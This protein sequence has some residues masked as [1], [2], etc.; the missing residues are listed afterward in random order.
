MSI[1]GKAY[2]V[3]AYE[4]PERRFRTGRWRRSTPRSPRA[5]WPD[6]GLSLSD[7]D[8]FF[9]RRE[10]LGMGAVS[11]AEYLGLNLSYIDSTESGGSSLLC[12]IGHAA[13]AI[14]E[15]KCTVALVSLAGKG[16]GRSAAAH[17]EAPE[18]GFEALFGPVT[19]PGTR[20]PRSATCTSS[21]RPASSWPR[22]RWPRRST[23]STTRT[24]CSRTRSPSRR[25]STRRCELTR[26][27]AS[28]ACVV[29]DGGGAVIVVSPE[30]AR[31]LPR[32]KVKIL[33]H[34]EAP[35]HT[36]NGRIDLTYTGARLVWSAGVR[37]GRR[38]RRATSTTPRS[39]TRSP[40]PSCCSWRTSASARKARVAQF[41]LDGALQSP[42]G[43]LPFNTDGGGLCN[44][45]PA[46]RGGMTKIIE[47]VRQLRGE[48]RPEVQV[49]ELRP[50]PGAR[51][52]RIDR[53][54]HGQRDAD[55]G[56]G[57]RVTDGCSAAVAGA[58]ANHQYR[59]QT[60]LGRHD[61]RR[62]VLPRCDACATVIWYPRAFCPECSSFDI[63]WFDASGRGTIYSYTVNRR[64]Q[65]DYRDMAYVLA[66][67]ELDEGP[68]VMTNIVDCDPDS[69][70]VGQAV[71]VVFHPTSAE[72]ALPRFR[73]LES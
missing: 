67:V 59:D 68:R 58:R 13:A 47:A 5:R 57:G 49:P 34:G 10:G 22:S 38:A 48:A 17:S 53:H 50:G 12:Q 8:G 61:R 4:H 66:Y 64:G 39:T 24:R 54:A 36:N 44:N 25:C 55:S 42:H 43:K 51:H 29:T 15:G 11:M 70:R 26:C 19:V 35:K 1:R 6:A 37:G 40:S 16:R 45:H 32:R 2:I 46:N 27:T 63:Q 31:E 71:Q 65:G 21:A 9:C 73:P 56:P 69:V 60:V 3:G 52:R 30:V 33:G 72:A 28:T 20:S 41:V 18:L 7:V 23:P 14:A 62:L